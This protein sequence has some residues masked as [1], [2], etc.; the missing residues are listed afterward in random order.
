MV[1]RRSLLSAVALALA[2]A[3]AHG[4]FEVRR[5]VA[6]ATLIPSANE[7]QEL[8]SARR[9]TQTFTPPAEPIAGV[10]LFVSR[11]PRIESLDIAIGVR[12][13]DREIG[14]GVVPIP[15][16]TPRPVRVVFPAHRATGAVT[17]EAW[18][19]A[20]RPGHAAGV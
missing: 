8:S 15:D 9:V 1:C 18:A 13:G 20:G 10:E 17:I 11:Y 4:G 5:V 19:P 3:A 14:F 16:Q 7:I 6:D 2:A 12:D